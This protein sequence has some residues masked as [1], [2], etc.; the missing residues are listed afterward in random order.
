M[1]FFFNAKKKTRVGYLITH[2]VICIIQCAHWLTLLYLPFFF[3]VGQNDVEK[4]T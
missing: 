1:F 3:L 2:G 4:W